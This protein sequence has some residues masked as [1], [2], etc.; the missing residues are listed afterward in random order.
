MSVLALMV[1]V[2][3][4]SPAGCTKDTDCKGD[5]ICEA[6]QCVN[7]PATTA[8]P[9]A[10][11]EPVVT[12]P[13]PPPAPAASSP[14]DYPKVV[15]KNGLTCI[16]SV[17][18]DGVVHEDCRTDTSSYSS[19]RRPMDAAASSAGAPSSSFPPEVA[20]AAEPPRSR[21]VADFGVLGS[22]NILAAGGSSA[23]L[24]GAALHLSVAGRVADVVSLGGALNANMGFGPGGYVLG[25]TFAPLLRLGDLSHASLVFGPSLFVASTGY[26]TTVSVIGTFLVHGVVI[27][28]GGFGIHMQLGVNFDASGAII[29]FAIG[30]GGS[31]L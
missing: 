15:R 8:A 10:V 30:F 21:V 16:Q 20:E 11:A 9:A 27:A 2:L 23:V 3:G 17:W 14:A 6:G 29:T 12:P 5:R 26:G 13:P 25:L 19:A 24:P 4:A 18:E 28:A 7:P 22:V 1:A 31:V